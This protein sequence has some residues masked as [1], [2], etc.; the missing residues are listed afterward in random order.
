[1]NTTKDPNKSGF[2]DICA[3]SILVSV[4][5]LEQPTSEGQYTSFEQAV[6]S[7]KSVRLDMYNGWV[8]PAGPEMRDTY[9]YRNKIAELWQLEPL[10]FSPDKVGWGYRWYDQAQ[11]SVVRVWMEKTSIWSR[12]AG[13][14]IDAPGP[15]KEEIRK[16]YLVCESEYVAFGQ[17][18]PD[19]AWFDEETREFMFDGEGDG[20]LE[21][22]C[23]V[24]NGLEKEYLD[25]DRSEEDGLEE[26]D[27]ELCGLEMGGL[28]MDDL[29]MAG[30]EG[31]HHNEDGFGEYG[32]YEDDRDEYIQGGSD[33]EYELRK[34]S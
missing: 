31:V 13:E 30:L 28:E 25:G 27:L 23:R 16:M 29:E 32:R 26:D 2:Q 4:D 9:P 33:G 12:E 10:D 22:D 34:S 21:E 6:A 1:M 5:K 17:A 11:N 24:E 19:N 20:D 18:V 15:T 8:T 3:W 7:L 14:T